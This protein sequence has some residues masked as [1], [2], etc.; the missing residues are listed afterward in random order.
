[1]KW[2]DKNPRGDGSSRR[3]PRLTSTDMQPMQCV[4][5]VRAVE[6]FWLHQGIRELV[7]HGYKIVSHSVRTEVG[8][9]DGEKQRVLIAT[10]VCETS[11][12]SERWEAAE[13]ARIA[14]QF[15]ARGPLPL[16]VM[17]ATKPT[18]AGNL[19]T[20][21]MATIFFVAWLAKGEPFWV[22]PGLA[23]V[24]SIAYDA[25]RW[26]QHRAYYPKKWYDVD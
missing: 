9:F 24:G 20:G 18:V 8:R 4:K 2:P 3:Q 23:L 17:L 22:L 15:K 25:W 11:D 5:T 14:A 10:C 12:E 1:M 26:K 6:E 21:I 16:S 13:R 7:S 19:A